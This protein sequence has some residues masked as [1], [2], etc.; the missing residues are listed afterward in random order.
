M[1]ISKEKAF[2]VNMGNYESFRFGGSVELE[3]SDLGL[4]PLDVENDLQGVVR[5][6][7]ERAEEILGEL[8]VQDV[9]DAADHTDERKSFVLEAAEAMK[10]RTKKRSQ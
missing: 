10:P 8:I 1:K 9:R 7:N 6:L 3:P 5:E 2:T 4:T